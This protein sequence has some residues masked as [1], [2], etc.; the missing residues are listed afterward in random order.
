MSAVRIRVMLVSAM[1]VMALAGCSQIDALAPVG[2]DSITSVRTAVNDV[3]VAEGVDLLVAPQCTQEPTQFTCAGS[4]V[5]GSPITATAELS[6]PYPLTIEVD[7][8]TL[9]TGTATDVLEAA[10]REAS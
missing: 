2:G 6:A 4:T 9:F 7:G 5:S 3:L 1:T 10:L 8:M